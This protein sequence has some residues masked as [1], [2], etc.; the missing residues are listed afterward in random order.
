MNK[1][2][3]IGAGTYGQVYAQ[4]L[5][6]KYNII[7]YIDDDNALIDKVIDGIT[8]LG[9]REFLFNNIEKNIS[10]FVPIGNNDIRVELMSTLN[11]KGFKTPS[12]IHPNTIIH[13]SV[14]IGD[15]VYVLPGTNIMPCTI[16]NNYTMISMGVNVAHHNV[17]N[18]GCFFSQGTNIGASIFI[19]EKAYFGIGSTAMTG[20]KR[21]GNNSLIGAG[22]VVT[23]D[24]PDNAIVAG[25]PAKIL[26]YK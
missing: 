21:I 8:V 1:A 19:E 23:T 22:A 16:I 11:S 25:V 7:G 26:R 17:I 18:K 15:G 4:Y 24:V 3:I 9:N 13:E 14:K 12:Y 20:I 5:K 6:E 10:I 2:I